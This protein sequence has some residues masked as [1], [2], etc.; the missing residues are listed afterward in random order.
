MDYMDNDDIQNTTDAFTNLMDLMD[1]RIIITKM[2]L[3]DH[4]QRCKWYANL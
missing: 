4:H 1:N 2:N 3:N